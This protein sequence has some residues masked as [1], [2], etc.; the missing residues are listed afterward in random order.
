MRPYDQHCGLAHALD[1]T[2]ERWTLLIVR[3]LLT[4]P[5]RYSDLAEGLVT[6]P[7]NLLASRLKGMESSGL[8][9]RRR[10]PAP[11]DSVVVYELT[12]LGESLGA[13][14]VELARWGMTTLSPTR[15]DRAFRGHWLVLALRAR[16]E[17]RAAEGVTESYEFRI[18]A[19]DV[20]S[21]E[22]SDGHGTARLGAASDPAVVIAADA[23]TF[24]AF[25]GGAITPEEAIERGATLD[26]DPSVIERMGAILPP[27][28]A[29]AAVA[30]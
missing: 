19:E 16:F 27:R 28:N 8:V 5:R 9:R 1:L 4:G 14:V 7:T 17:P 15:E 25:S 11:A 29:E 26:G 22:V 23:D 2:G 13:S 30:A 3:E 18:D 10:L 12:E 21:F 20:V 6:V 24:L